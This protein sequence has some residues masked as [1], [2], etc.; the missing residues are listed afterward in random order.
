MKRIIVVIA[1]ILA[2]L[3]PCQAVG[4]IK[5]VGE[6]DACKDASISDEARDGAG[7]NETRD[8][9]DVAT[10]LIDIAIGI[11]GLVSVVVIVFA[12]QRYITSAGNPSKVKEA[13]DMILYGVIGAVV[14]I[15]AWA[16]I[17]FIIN[18]GV[19]S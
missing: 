14:A 6:S 13:K 9:L 5:N 1:I 17:T 3:L 10:T 15:L 12:G 2:G 11:V 4:A 19:F 16:I 18:T 7:C 8:G